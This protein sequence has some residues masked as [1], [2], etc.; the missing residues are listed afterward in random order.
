MSNELRWYGKVLSPDFTEVSVIVLSDLHYGNPFCSLK[1][2]QRTLDFIKGKNLNTK[3][4][5]YKKL[6]IEEL[7]GIFWQRSGRF[8][9]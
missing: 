6:P 1:H 9:K 3:L 5:E 8:S 7:T 4:E 2:F